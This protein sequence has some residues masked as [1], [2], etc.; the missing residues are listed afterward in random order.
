MGAESKRRAGFAIFKQD[1]T[2]EE[3]SSNAG[4]RGGVQNRKAEHDSKF[5]VA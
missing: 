2:R 4:Q 5:K 1:K 3:R